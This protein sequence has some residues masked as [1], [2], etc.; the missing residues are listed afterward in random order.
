[1]SAKYAVVEDCN[2]MEFD[3][4]DDAKEACLDAASSDGTKHW[5]VCCL[6]ETIP[7]LKEVVQ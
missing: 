6:A 2:L 3:T 5:V 4:L 7:T 1:M